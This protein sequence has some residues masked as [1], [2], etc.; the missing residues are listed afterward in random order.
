M[1]YASLALFL[2]LVS[3]CSQGGKSVEHKRDFAFFQPMI[4]PASEYGQA[5]QKMQELTLVTSDQKYNMRYALFD[6]G[7]FYYEVSNLGTGNGTWSYKDGYINLF[8]SR[9]FFDL[10]I[11]IFAAEAE[12]DALAMS[13][14]DRY[15]GNVVTAT[16]RMPSGRPLRQFTFPENSA[17]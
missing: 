2:I 8:S 5:D 4:N 12:G 9:T 10:D 6:N 16:T 3:A 14:L 17:L 13:F 15:G 1:K 11:D 7:K